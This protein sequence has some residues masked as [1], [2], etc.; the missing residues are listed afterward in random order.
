MPPPQMPLQCRSRH[1]IARARWRVSGPFRNAGG[2][3][4][5]SRARGGRR[6]RAP[7]LLPAVMATVS[8]HCQL[9]AIIQQFKLPAIASHCQPLAQL[10]LPA[11]A[12]RLARRCSCP[13]RWQLSLAIAS[14][15]QLPS[16]VNCPPKAMARHCVAA[17]AAAGKRGRDEA[18]RDQHGRG[19]ASRLGPPPG[20]KPSRSRARVARRCHHRRLAPMA[21][22]A[23]QQACRECDATGTCSKETTGHW[24]RIPSMGHGSCSNFN[25]C[26]ISK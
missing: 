6:P 19:E 10:L 2:G 13:L 22:P 26:F 5:C 4:A 14:Q 11:P 12:P 3:G 1:Q 15:G 23:V 21:R 25:C 18:C 8:D 16:I 24:S 7:L 17:A 9:R 20:P